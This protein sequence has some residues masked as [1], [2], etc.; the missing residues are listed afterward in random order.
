LLGGG[1]N[2]RL[3]S[4]HARNSL[5]NDSS[6]ALKLKSTCYPSISNFA[7]RK[8]H[9]VSYLDF[10]RSCHS[11][12]KLVPASP[13]SARLTIVSRLRKVV[14]RNDSRGVPERTSGS[15]AELS[16]DASIANPEANQ[17]F[18]TKG[19]LS[20]ANAAGV[21]EAERQRSR[22]IFP[23]DISNCREDRSAASAR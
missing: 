19:E 15:E 6:S 13:Q 21:P 11:K 22:G 9:S 12:L 5:R 4:S 18:A 2:F 10:D 16:R 1:A 20:R 7:M 3:A 17:G 23:K 14:P 8:F